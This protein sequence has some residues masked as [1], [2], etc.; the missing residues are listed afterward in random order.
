MKRLTIFAVLLA[1]LLLAAACNNV[2]NARNGSSN[3]GPEKD[4][5]PSPDPPRNGVDANGNA[6]VNGNAGPTNSAASQNDALRN[7]FWTTAAQGGIAEVELGQIAQTKAA[8]PEVKNFARMMVEDHTKANAELKSLAAKKNVTLPT[9]MN[10]GNQATL[11]ELQNLVGADFDREYVAA[12]VD[13]HEADVQLFESQAAD[14]SDPDAKAF[15]TKTLPT[16]RKHLEM[17]K[18]I[19]AKMR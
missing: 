17:I 6:T 14:D 8:N 19:Q 4:S 9:T 18:G 7:N 13:D 11:T 12:M 3:T 2:D 5:L 1:S 15:A 16:L 10:S